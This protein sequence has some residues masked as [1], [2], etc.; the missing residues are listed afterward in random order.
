[1]QITAIIGIL[2]PFS[3]SLENSTSWAL[4]VSLRA[5]QRVTLADSSGRQVGELV[6]V[7]PILQPIRVN[8]NG[9]S[10]YLLM[11]RS[12]FEVNELFEPTSLNGYSV[13]SDK[14]I[15]MGRILGCSDAVSTKPT[16]IIPF[17]LLSPMF[18]DISVENQKSIQNYITSMVKN[19]WP[20]EPIN[21]TT[22]KFHLTSASTFMTA[23]ELA[24]SSLGGGTLTVKGDT[25][26]IQRGPAPLLTPF[27]IS[28][29][30][31]IVVSGHDRAAF[32]SCSG[33]G[34]GT[35]TGTGSGLGSSGSFTGGGGDSCALCSQP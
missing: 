1:M 19:L 11:V 5:N 28:E 2:D 34:T 33:T 25:I 16:T 22:H 21:W 20:S 3:Y 13:Q 27:E 15:S 30:A 9:R 7:L 8:A 32:G 26:L 6:G 14:N 17:F 29:G 23:S 18:L 35:G 10:A 12:N 31:G 4:T 24:A